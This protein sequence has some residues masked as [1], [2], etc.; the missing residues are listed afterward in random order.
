M[1]SSNFFVKSFWNFIYSGR[2]WSPAE[3]RT[4]SF[5]NGF[6][7]IGTSYV[8]IFGVYRV[9]IGDY[10][11]GTIE[12]ILSA[13]S[14]ANIWYLR[15]SFNTALAGAVLLFI[16]I[17]VLAFLL[18]EGGVGQAGI[19]WI[20]TFPILA[21]FLFDSARGLRWNMALLSVLALVVLFSTFNFFTLPYPLIFL[22]Q[23][24]FSYLAVIGILYVYTKF[25][26]VNAQILAERT[27]EIE[28]SFELQKQKIKTASA[29]TEQKL[30]EKLGTFFNISEDLM[31]IANFDAYFIEMNPAFMEVLGY[32][33]DELRRTSFIEF[34]YHEDV[35][36]TKEAMQ[37]LKLG[38]SIENFINRYQKK[39]GSYA[40][41][42]WNA[43]PHNGFVYATARV[44]TELVEVRK[45]LEERIK[46]FEDMNRLMVGRELIMIEM[47][48][49]LA[50]L[51]GETP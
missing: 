36:K 16:M 35:E 24:L 12:L 44:V 37:K 22:R 10:V 11:G 14:L 15:K 4:V 50:K 45:K 20:Y 30:K 29:E 27:K 5:I 42:M 17:V 19:L 21:F 51:K 23:A 13:I 46:E 32:S 9:F 34:V 33:E 18:I 47:K 3:S 7:I 49:E 43:I 31:C 39:D 8:I 6:S 48:K 41:L 40:W 28:S 2:E 38:E 26:V 25:N 1:G